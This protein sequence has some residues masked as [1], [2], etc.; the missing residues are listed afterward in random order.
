MPIKEP[1]EDDTKRTR[2]PQ[3][4]FLV[5]PAVSPT[6]GRHWKRRKLHQK[7]C[8]G[9][10]DLMLECERHQRF[11]S[12]RCRDRYRYKRMKGQG[13]WR[14]KKT[15][16]LLR[17]M[18]QLTNAQ[19]ARLPIRSKAVR[20][21][22]E[23]AYDPNRLLRGEDYDMQKRAGIIGSSLEL[24]IPEEMEHELALLYPVLPFAK[25]AIPAGLMVPMVL[26]GKAIYGRGAFAQELATAATVGFRWMRLLCQNRSGAKA[27]QRGS[28][29]AK[30]ERLM[31]ANGFKTQLE[32]SIPGKSVYRAWKKQNRSGP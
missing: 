31:K 13:F 28:E 26:D 1:H 18:R 14:D 30:A 16:R 10:G 24:P 25:D 11:H 7:V 27:F 19:M 2:D 20:E 23:S 22:D 8:W 4:R 29:V 21:K 32:S 12:D 3:G 6:L 5:G 15:K 9:C 17:K